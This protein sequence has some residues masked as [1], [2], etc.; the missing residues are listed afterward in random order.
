MVKNTGRFARNARTLMF[1][2]ERASGRRHD[3]RQWQLDRQIRHHFG[4]GIPR[5][6]D[7]QEMALTDFLNDIEGQLRTNGALGYIATTIAGL[8]A[9]ITVT[10]PA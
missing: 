5:Y 4:G 7:A 1:R 9:R 8:R 2:A 3:R 6:P 10:F